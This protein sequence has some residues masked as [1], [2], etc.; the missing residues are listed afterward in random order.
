[1]RLSTEARGKPSRCLD[2]DLFLRSTV[3]TVRA[4]SVAAGPW[5]CVRAQYQAAEN[6]NTQR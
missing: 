2:L 3:D 6:Q 5:A 4:V 1:M